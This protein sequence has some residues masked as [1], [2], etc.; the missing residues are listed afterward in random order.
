[1][2]TRLLASLACLFLLGAGV[3]SATGVDAANSDIAFTIKQMGVNLD[4]RF[5]KWKGDVVFDPGAL[6][7]SRAAAV[8]DDVPKPGFLHEVTPVWA[9]PRPRKKAT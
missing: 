8:G 4:G 7:K 9:V 5:R 6:D 2:M 1:M 3:A